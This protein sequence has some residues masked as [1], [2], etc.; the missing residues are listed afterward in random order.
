M[1]ELCHERFDQRLKEHFR[2]GH[3]ESEHRLHKMLQVNS[4]RS[5]DGVH[6]VGYSQQ[7]SL[8]SAAIELQ[9]LFGLVLQP[10]DRV[11]VTVQCLVF[12]LQKIIVLEQVVL[13]D[14]ILV[15]DGLAQLF[16][17]YL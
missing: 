17:V 9:Y 15:L 12:L 7:V 6:V 3:Q 2:Y 13:Q 14:A 1:V 16:P 11:D 4:R 8:V 10:G 5:V